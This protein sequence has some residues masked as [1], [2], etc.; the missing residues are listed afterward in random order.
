MKQRFYIF[1][2]R[3]TWYFEDGQSGEQKSLGT[4]DKSE[5]V[6]LLEI[7]RQSAS[8]PAFNQL[9]LKTCLSFN[10]GLL[11]K[12][13]WTEV[14]NQIQSHG[15]ESTQSRC[16]I[17]V[18]NKAFDR[19]RNKK[20]IETT[21]DDLLL[22][23]RGCRVSVNHY[24]RRFHNLA[25]GLG[26]LPTPILPS[27]LWPKPKCKDKR[28]ITV[29]EHQAILDA[30]KNAERSLYYQLLWETGAA[31]TDAAFLR[32]EQIDWKARTLA[33]QR[34]KT[35]SWCGL[36]IGGALEKILQQLPKEGPFFPSISKTRANDRASE[37]Y[38]RVKLLEI[39]GV[40]LHSYRY[41]W[42][43]RAK[44]VG[45]PERFAQ[46]ALGH[47]S[48][49]VHRYYSKNALVTVPSLEDYAQ[50]QKGKTG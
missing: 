16:K 32:A 27:K 36:A 44:C 35:E 23:L 10:D 8:N 49:A 50:E 30:E 34:K 41:A 17:A 42:A 47:N 4:Q 40:S 48:K 29:A 38:R 46:Q 15:K 12:R 31:Q 13:T 21:S 28:A 9:M 43:E 18:A 24:L 25:L 45:F 39:K 6:R 20:L 14:M 5:A 19:I 3:K 2:R 22:I 11:A 37:F 33:F 26:W 1:K 7:K